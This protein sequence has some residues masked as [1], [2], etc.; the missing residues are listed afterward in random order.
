M[1]ATVTVLLT[2]KGHMH[3]NNV[4][5][6]AVG[7]TRGSLFPLPYV[8]STITTSRKYHMPS[9]STAPLHNRTTAT[10]VAQVHFFPWDEGN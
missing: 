8:Q 1:S 6:E 9:H 2:L 7:H 3:R 10:R 5:T 4:L